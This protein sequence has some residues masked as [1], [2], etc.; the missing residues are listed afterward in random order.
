MNFVCVEEVKGLRK[1]VDLTKSE[2]SE[3]TGIS[4]NRIDNIENKKSRMFAEDV[5]CL[6]KIFEP[7]LPWLILGRD[8]NLDE[9]KSS[10]S[11]I[12]NLAGSKFE[13]GKYPE[14]FK[15]KFR[16]FSEQ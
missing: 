2:F 10:D 9:L 16:S 5:I 4:L 15:G 11:P 8:I 3:L 14:V 1:L 12:L 7:F 13:L 6:A